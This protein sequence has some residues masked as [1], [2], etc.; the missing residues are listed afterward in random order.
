[1]AFDPEAVRDQTAHLFKRNDEVPTV[2]DEQALEPMDPAETTTAKPAA[3]RAAKTATAK[4]ADKPV[5]KGAGPKKP[6]P[7]RAPRTA[8]AK[9]AASDSVNENP[10]ALGVSSVTVDQPLDQG[11]QPLNF[12]YNG[13]PASLNLQDH[14]PGQLPEATVI[15]PVLP[16]AP[17]VPNF[18]FNGQPASLVP[19]S[20]PLTTDSV[21]ANVMP[22]VAPAVPESG[23]GAIP[24]DPLKSDVTENAAAILEAMPATPETAPPVPDFTF[25]GQ[26]APLK[27]APAQMSTDPVSANVEPDVAPAVPESG[28]GAIPSDFLKSDVPEN[29][30]AVLE[31]MPATAQAAPPVPNFTF[32]GQPASLRPAPVQMSADPV[33]ANVEPE[34]A[35]AVLESGSGAIP[36]D[37][38]KSDVLEVAP[39]MQEALPV[40]SEVTKVAPSDPIST[41]QSAQAAQAVKTNSNGISRWIENVA[42]FLPS[43]FRSKN[44]TAGSVDLEALSPRSEVTQPASSE[45]TST[46]KNVEVAPTVTSSANEP[47]VDTASQPLPP[48]VEVEQE[49]SGPIEEPIAAKPSEPAAEETPSLDPQ[50]TATARPLPS[51]TEAGSSAEVE[52]DGI[53][54]G[55]RIG[56]DEPPAQPSDI[57]K[58][59][60]L[61]RITHETQNDNSV[62]YNHDSEP[63]YEDRGSR[64]EMVPGA[65]TSDEKIMAALL[66]AARF[67]RGQIELTGSDAFKTKAIELI[68]QHQVNVS[69]KNPAQQLM[70]DQARKALAVTAQKPDA[71]LGN[72]PPPFEPVVTSQHE[73]QQAAMPLQPQLRT[74]LVTP[75]AQSL[76]EYLFAPDP[77][78]DSA[79]SGDLQFENHGHAQPD[80]TME[81]SPFSPDKPK[82]VEP[83]VHQP[84]QAAKDGVTGKVIGFGTAPFRFDPDNQ[85]SVYIKLRTK[86]GTQTFWGKELAGVIRETRIQEGRMATLRWLGE[87]DVTVNVPVRDE[88]GKV[89]RWVEKEAHR[90]QWSLSLLNG[91]AVRTGDDQGIK[92]AAYDA[93]RFAMIQNSVIAQLNLPIE[94]PSLPDGGLLWVAPNGQGSAKA[95]DELSAPRPAIDSQEA[96][97]LVM[98]SWSQDGQLDMALYRGDGA[99]LQGI[100]RQG[101]AYQHVLVSLPGHAEAPPMVFNMITEQGLVPIGVGNGI[102]RSNGEAV[103]REHVAFKLEGDTVTR[104]AKLDFPAEVP[105]ALHHRLGFDERWK[106][107]NT[108][109]KS[110][111]AAAPVAQPGAL[112]PS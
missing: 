86:E 103:S 100:V 11:P 2:S 10:P 53:N 71:I 39:T 8:A 68:A 50:D 45:A 98:S 55:P 109:P 75:E 36:S 85:D 48:V 23:T 69:M 73:L 67:Y 12:V 21:S 102:N 112:R 31:A 58:D 4:P 108:L 77:L 70:L 54:V 19:G 18:T 88:A 33:S 74:E 105:P 43:R 28:P 82:N 107:T 15:R 101:D 47:T 99:Y 9:S 64:L 1:V 22:D 80:A 93:A 89:V 26:S 40:S 34:V 63:A 16:T 110:A 41:V 3:K 106:D 38:L 92:L 52:V 94:A 30:A 76:P 65:G 37:P 111:P 90:N 57:D 17:P 32:N 6:T 46:A 24:S 42:A 104:V 56:V 25:N 44:A 35:P 20:A 61:T 49:V 83:S 60:L 27:P 91:P 87:K 62:L 66:T 97:K 78:S 29:A 96:G 13:Q 51:K 7:R 72:T 81:S 5:D 95:G 59:A 79:Y 14:L 84:S